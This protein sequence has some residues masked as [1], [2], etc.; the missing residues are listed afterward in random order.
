MLYQRIENAIAICDGHIKSLDPT[1]MQ[2]K[3]LE[4][5]LVAG[6]ILLI[7]SEYEEYLESIFVKR[8]ELCGDLY[9]T[10]YIKKTLSQKFRSPDLSK[11]NETLKRFDTTYKESFLSEVENSPNHAAWDSLLKARHAVVHKK[12]SLNLTF[13]ELKSNYPLTKKVIENVEL[14]LGIAS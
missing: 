14:T 4:T 3:E 2:D 6:L 7:V 8:A 12:G 10:N 11:I 13:L 1:N 5:F 9:A